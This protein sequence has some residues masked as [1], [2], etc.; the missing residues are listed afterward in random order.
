MTHDWRV[1]RLRAF[2]APL[3]MT[4]DWR[5]LRLRVRSTTALGASAQDDTRRLD[6][7]AEAGGGADLELIEHFLGRNVRG[8][9]RSDDGAEQS[10]GNRDEAGIVERKEGVRAHQ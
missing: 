6:F 9:E 7:G 3:R 1:L 5:V 10:D 4:H 2:G 8:D